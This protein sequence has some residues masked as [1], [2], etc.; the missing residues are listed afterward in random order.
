MGADLDSATVLFLCDAV[1]DWVRSGVRIASGRSGAGPIW[2]DHLQV[3]G[4]HPAVRSS[5]DLYSGDHHHA[6]A[7]HPDI[8]RNGAAH[9]SALRKLHLDCV[10]YGAP[11][12]E[13]DRH[14]IACTTRLTNFFSA[15]LRLCLAR[16]S[17]HS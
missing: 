9:V 3:H 7:R 1:H 10:A 13:T 4:P 8:G 12:P 5:A 11:P 2:L 16:Q 17:A 6:Y 14:L 15:P